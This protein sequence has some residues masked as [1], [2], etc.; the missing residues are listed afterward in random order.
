MHSF[1]KTYFS[2]NDPDRLIEQ[3]S[4]SAVLR[5]IQINP[6]ASVVNIHVGIL[7]FIIQDLCILGLIGLGVLSLIVLG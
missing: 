1:S 6:L 2:L 4:G 7:E 5:F 3:R